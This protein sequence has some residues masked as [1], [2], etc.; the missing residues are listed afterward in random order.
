[1]TLS[2]I[3]FDSGKILTEFIFELLY[4]PIWWYSR[5]LLKM[6][7]WS[8]NFLSRKIKST[9]LLIWLKNIFTPMYG[10]NDWAGILISFITR[11]LQ[12]IFRSLAMLFWI[13]WSIGIIALWLIFPIIVILEIIFQLGII[14]SL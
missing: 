3:I 2:S 10:Q 14:N 7:L 8:K 9:G 1:M 11:I 12:I 6:L 13:I 4:F 5:G